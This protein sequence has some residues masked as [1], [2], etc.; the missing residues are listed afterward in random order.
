MISWVQSKIILYQPM[1]SCCGYLNSYCFRWVHISHGILLLANWIASLLSIRLKHAYWIT[2]GI[3]FPKVNGYIYKNQTC[4]LWLLCNI[5]SG[6][7]IS[8]FPSSKFFTA[9]FVMQT[10][11]DTSI[12]HMNCISKAHS[13]WKSM[14][15]SLLGFTCFRLL[16]KLII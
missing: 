1:S 13:L 14:L 6:I 9:I 5:A 11:R 12:S 3:R 2:T 16:K 7:T 10:K 15:P 4:L 8:K